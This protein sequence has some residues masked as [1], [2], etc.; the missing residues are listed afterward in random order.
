MKS[1]RELIVDAAIGHVLQRGDN[2]V[3]QVCVLGSSITPDQ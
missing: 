2:Q 1:S 3:P